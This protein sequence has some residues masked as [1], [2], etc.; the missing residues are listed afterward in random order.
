VCLQVLTIGATN[1]AADLDQALLRPGRFEAVYEIPSPNPTARLEILKYHARCVGIAGVESAAGG[2]IHLRGMLV[3][4]G[5][6]AVLACQ[7]TA[8]CWSSPCSNKPLDSDG[9]LVRV[10]E[11]TQGWS[12]AALANLMN[13]AA[14]LTVRRHDRCQPQG[15]LSAPAFAVATLGSACLMHA[16]ARDW[17][18]ALARPCDPS[19]WS[20]C[21]ECL[22]A[23]LQV[24]RG[25]S[26]ISLPMI[27][28]VI[29]AQ[30]RAADRAGPAKLPSAICPLRF[31]HC[32]ALCATPW[33]LT[34][35]SRRVVPS[36]AG[37]G[38]RGSQ[39][40]AE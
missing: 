11:V 24:R 10:A 5:C 33:P 39:D 35:P 27:M 16:S 3:V 32:P 6:T 20:R 23:C 21:A 25:V 13:E 7:P 22:P 29:N 9:M 28:D 4:K 15:L 26:K 36:P 12:A 8:Q 2:C 31:G 1:L 14:I 18:L 37:V 17:W 19:Q 30:V 38:H 34:C 40:P